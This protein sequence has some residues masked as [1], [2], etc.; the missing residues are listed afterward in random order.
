[1]KEAQINAIDCPSIAIGPW[2]NSTRLDLGCNIAESPA[3]GRDDRKPMKSRPTADDLFG[4]HQG[5]ETK[6][7]LP[8]RLGFPV[9]RGIT[10]T[11]QRA[12]RNCAPSTYFFEPPQG[13]VLMSAINAATGSHPNHARRPRS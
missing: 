8:V 1:M 5:R 13:A 12:N 10:D 3:R 6:P 4:D 2:A 7:G 9:P 11:P